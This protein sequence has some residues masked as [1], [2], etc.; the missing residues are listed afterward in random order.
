MV[1]VTRVYLI[2][3]GVCDK[4]VSDRRWCTCDKCVS[5]E[6]MREMVCLSLINLSLRC[7]TV[8]VSLMLAICTWVFCIYCPC[9]RQVDID[10]IPKGSDL[11]SL[12]HSEMGMCQ[13]RAVYVREGR[14]MSEKGGVC[15]RMA[16]VR[17][18]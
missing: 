13:R 10:P 15:Q 11:Y 2:G 1:S 7:H 16:C 9:L 6:S 3:D 8:M 5:D 18:K 12:D 17:E 14:C 4:C